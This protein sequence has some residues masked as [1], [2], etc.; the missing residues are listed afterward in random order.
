MSAIF[1]AI[2]SHDALKLRSLLLSGA[3][4]MAPHPEDDHWLPLMSAVDEIAAGGSIDAVMLLLRFGASPDPPPP[5]RRSTPLLLAVGEQQLDVARLLLTAGADS[6]V[7]DN[8]GLSPL[9]LAVANNAVPMTSLLLIGGASESIDDSR[10]V[11]G[12]SALG[13]AV[14]RLNVPMIKLLIAAGANPTHPDCDRLVAKDYLPLRSS[15]NADKWDQA[16]ALLDL[17]SM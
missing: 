11:A 12:M 17:S 4:P 3:D 8:E 14:A 10:G 9:R 7:T 13:I 6:S 5:P 1:Q 16:K 2:E 15:L